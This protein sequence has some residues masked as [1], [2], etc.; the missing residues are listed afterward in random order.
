MK[1]EELVFSLGLLCKL[2]EGFFVSYLW[3][4]SVKG[5]VQY[6]HSVDN[7]FDLHTQIFESSV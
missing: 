1:G 3:L 7:Y 5:A 2:S 6:E 4:D